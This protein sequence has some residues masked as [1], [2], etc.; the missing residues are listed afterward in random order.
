M[1]IF[2]RRGWRPSSTKIG[3]YF[4]LMEEFFNAVDRA[5]T[6]EANRIPLSPFRLELK[7][8][9]ELP[10]SAPEGPLVA[11]P[12]KRRGASV[13]NSLRERRIRTKTG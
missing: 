2:S 13:H 7:T 10:L 3:E 6:R 1:W 12:S 9:L 5:F 11:R 4:M 8:S